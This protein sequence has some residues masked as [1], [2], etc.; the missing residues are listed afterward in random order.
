M[1]DLAGAGYVSERVRMGTGG[2]SA[3]IMKQLVGRPESFLGDGRTFQVKGNNGWYDVTV[4]LSRDPDERRPVIRIRAGQGDTETKLYKQNA[5]SGQVGAVSRSGNNFGVQG[6]AV[7]L[8][9]TPVPG[10]LAG[11]VVA[12][13]VGL[14]A[15]ESVVSSQQTVSE[16]SQFRSE[17]GT[18]TVR[19]L[20]R[21]VVRIQKHGVPTARTLSGGGKVT[22][23]IPR[24]HLMPA[25]SGPP[26]PV[27]TTD[28]HARL[29]K[30]VSL[31][32]LA[33]TH[34]G[35]AYEG[36]KGIFDKVRSVLHP[37]LTASGSD[38]RS[39]ALNAS[40]A[41]RLLQELPMMLKHW[42]D[43]GDLSSADGQVH[44]SFRARAEI[45]DLALAGGIGS[46]LVRNYQQAKHDHTAARSRTAGGALS[47]GAAVG[48]G[49]PP[50]AHP[51]IRADLRPGL[52][53]T[54][55]RSA[56]AGQ[57]VTSRQ[58]AE[59]RGE[60]RLY[61]ARVKFFFEGSGP[62]TP[63]MRAGRARAATTHLATVWLSIRADEA[64]KLLSPL[65]EAT[66]A[67]AT[68]AEGTEVE[69][70]EAEGAKA[71]EFIQPPKDKGNR[72][73]PFGGFGNS[74]TLSRVDTA[75]LLKKIEELFA[76]D[77]RLAGFLP[78]YGSSNDRGGPR[79]WP[80][81]SDQQQVQEN[82]RALT[83]GLSETNVKARKDVLLSSGIP[84]RLK[85][86]RPTVTE[87]A[88]IRVR[89]K[90]DAYTYRGEIADWRVRSDHGTAMSVQS[91]SSSRQT[92]GI[93]GDVRGQA[94]PGYFSLGG[95]AAVIGHSM[96]SNQVGVVG[97]NDSV[98]IGAETASAFEG[99][100]EFAVDIEIVRRLRNWRRAVPGRPGRH[101]PDI[102]TIDGFTASGDGD[103]KSP[104][105]WTTPTPLTLREQEQARPQSQGE[106]EP[107][108]MPME[109][110]KVGGI[111]EMLDPEWRMSAADARP[112]VTEWVYAENTGDWAEIQK[113]A[114][115]LLTKAAGGDEALS[116]RGLD[117]AVWV[118]EKF[119]PRAIA[120][121][122]VQGTR[123]AWTVDDLQYS[124]RIHGLRGAVGTRFDLV[125]PKVLQAT[126]GF[127]TENAVAGGHQ[128]SAGKGG[129]WSTVARLVGSASE[130]SGRSP[131]VFETIVPGYSLSRA[132]ISSYGIGGTIER[133]SVT[134]RGQRLFLVQTDVEVAMTAE[135]AVGKT[136]GGPKVETGARRIPAARALWLTEDQ[137]RRFGLGHEVDK[138]TG[139]KPEAET[140]TETETNLPAGPV[141][142]S[143]HA[144]RP[145]LNDSLS[146]GFGLIEDVPRFDRL[147]PA[148]HAELARRR[149]RKFAEK[150]LPTGRL[151]DRWSNRQ[152]LSNVL[153]RSGAP[154][155]MGSAMDGGVTVE[156]FRDDGTAYWAVFT[157]TRKPSEYMDTPQ[158]RRGMEYTTAAISQARSRKDRI[159]G[160]TVPIVVSPVGTGT[161]DE[162]GVGSMGAAVGRQD[163][164]THSTMDQQ[165][166]GIKIAT[167]EANPETARFRVPI[168]A[169]L[170]LYSAKG[171]VASVSL[172]GPK[173]GPDDRYM[174]YRVLESDRRILAEVKPRDKQSPDSDRVAHTTVDALSAAPEALKTWRDGGAHLP[175]Q[176]QVNN[177][178]GVPD[179]RNA[180]EDA[181][182]RVGAASVFRKR[183]NAAAYALS[184]SVS[185][186]W[187]VAA[188]PW[189]TDGVDLP[190]SHASK[191]FGG[192]DLGAS[193]HARLTRGEV[194]GLG[195]KMTFE[196][197]AGS[198]PGAPRHVAAENQDGLASTQT[199]GF[200]PGGTDYHH[201]PDHDYRGP[202]A[203]LQIGHT[204]ETQQNTGRSA[205]SIPHVVATESAALV[206]FDLHIR[207]VVRLRGRIA[208]T[209]RGGST[210]AT[211]TEVRLSHPL[212]VRIRRSAAEAMVKR[213]DATDPRH[214]LGPDGIDA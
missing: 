2:D 23:E 202:Q 94:V 53:S 74:V 164:T 137:A 67:E 83:T 148:L 85:R 33:M 43:F 189:L 1:T 181:A 68:K 145:R 11:P 151:N 200:M 71:D 156:L 198:A 38:G 63:E 213:G 132:S 21:Y 82:Y 47:L 208:G 191:A 100:V 203:V 62:T 177:F 199:S 104:A 207:A 76:K 9:P 165:Q 91:G 81:A 8:V 16:S 20:V 174:T 27:S 106:A 90:A 152:R 155:L 178:Q 66:D 122:L 10:L 204:H 134:P 98:N 88:T 190:E 70:T 80:V 126:T 77:P 59:I 121:G 186:E 172:G 36:G 65:P 127:G 154:A 96:R 108:E 131:G 105:L 42:V 31:D 25:G 185:H 46:G 193:L 210:A 129:G 84:I 173:D 166:L 111:G 79:K 55:A 93:E 32:P 113:L 211:A 35:G 101:L 139:R 30:A 194:L 201:T 133:R 51:G 54:W 197:V 45:V 209:G 175:S 34:T 29:G 97:Q 56:S 41:D 115:E 72:F 28:P 205:G 69:A 124:R 136:W 187:L 153:G 116:V 3:H 4:A 183:G 7:V 123:T 6:G 163:S 171:L 87:T 107:M 120:A 19:R 162:L 159:G 182:K 17:G 138:A 57:S 26:K 146:L 103:G 109:M 170:E 86:Q 95:G 117:P 14:P 157:V 169:K 195:D 50:A 39:V 147:L 214:A 13:R 102:E 18:V 143:A 128:A 179:I 15:T 144:E 168:D 92:M 188:L 12:G 58:G 184:G 110:P 212:I 161:A 40:S 118:E 5:A 125:N 130:E 196:A 24:E 180:L 64:A 89:A 114:H 176:V 99:K 135:V 192:Q 78:K 48:V 37:V 119:S 44:G 142:A 60:K 160:L 73:L 150:L 61:Q 158:D 112:R 149:D 140:E 52:G 49:L 167:T 22:T 206:K 141:T 75:P